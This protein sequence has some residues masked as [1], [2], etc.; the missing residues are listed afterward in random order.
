MS[1]KSHCIVCLRTYE[2]EMPPKRQGV[3]CGY[4]YAIYEG[5]HPYDCSKLDEPLVKLKKK[6]KKQKKIY[7][8]MKFQIQRAFFIFYPYID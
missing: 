4:K 1:S 7:E 6:A 3:G 5:S 8:E 2:G